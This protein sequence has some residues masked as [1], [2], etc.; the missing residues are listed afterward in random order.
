MRRFPIDDP[1]AGSLGSVRYGR[2][3]LALDADACP[4]CGGWVVVARRGNHRAL[5]NWITVR[6]YDGPVGERHRC[7]AK[8]TRQRHP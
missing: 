2:A 4:E 6:P 8:T 5:Y 1:R 7:P 3:L